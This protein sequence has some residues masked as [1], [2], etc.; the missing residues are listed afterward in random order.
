MQVEVGSEGAVRGV[1]S[2]VGEG[3]HVVPVVVE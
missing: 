1:T 3:G 2:S